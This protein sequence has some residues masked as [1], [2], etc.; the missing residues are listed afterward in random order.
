MTSD[1]FVLD[2]GDGHRIGVHEWRAADPIG[3]LIWLHGMG[4][5][6]ARYQALGEIL[7]EHGWNLYCP[8]HRGHGISQDADQP[9]GHFG[10]QDG[11][12]KVIGD[13]Q[14]VVEAVAERDPG[15]LVLGGHSMGSFIALAGAERF[16][17]R[18]DG[19]VLCGSDYHS[20]G[21][22]RSLLPVIRWQQRRQGPRGQ[23]ALID[24]LTFGAWARS[25]RDARTDFD[26]LSHDQDQVDAYIDDPLCG[27]Q[28]TNATWVA[29][30]AALARVQGKRGLAALPAGLPVL[31]LGGRQDPMS[32]F[33]KGMDRLENALRRRGLPLRRLDCPEGRH[34]ILNDY[35]APEVRQTL[36]E[37]LNRRL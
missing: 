31:L 28:C 26:W 15:P 7:A 25:V 8:D 21:Y 10:D 23:S 3:T 29:L 17:E 14:R 4:E 33:G 11:W 6:G 24:K 9:P 34:E 20:A 19:L 27:F 13:V 5:H 18:L 22:Y 32:N 16:G 36:L 35:C 30:V 1:C 12:D 2:A 37:W